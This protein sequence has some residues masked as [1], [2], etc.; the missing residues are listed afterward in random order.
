[1]DDH[2]RALADK[3]ME[4]LRTMV[5][6]KMDSPSPRQFGFIVGALAIWSLII[7][8]T[9]GKLPEEYKAACTPEELARYIGVT[10]PS[11]QPQSSDS[12]SE[13]ANKNATSCDSG[14][15]SS[16]QSG[17]SSDT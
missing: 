2:I 14:D 15:S 11:A 17:S 1:M 16:Q 5:L 4:M 13:N 9:M 8:P 7:E 12:A 3:L 6:N 10:L